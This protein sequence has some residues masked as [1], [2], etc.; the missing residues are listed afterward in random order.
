MAYDIGPRI[1]LKGEKEFNQQLI[2]INNSLKE[3]GSELKAVSSQFDDNANSQEAL[4]AKNKVLEKQYE[5][6]QQKLKLFQGQL[7]KQKS[8]L[9]EQESRNKKSNCSVWRKTQKK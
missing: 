8:L 1:T 6:Q 9:S 3:Y 5:T 7:E 2:K 4:I